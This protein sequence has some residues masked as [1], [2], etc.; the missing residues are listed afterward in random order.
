MIMPEIIASTRKR[1]SG[2]RDSYPEYGKKRASL[3]EAIRNCQ[4]KNP[5]IAE[6]KYSSP[7]NGFLGSIYT[8]E[9]IAGFYTRGG[10]TAIS[11]LTEPEYFKGSNEFLKRV[12]NYSNCPVLRKDFIIDIR[13]L[14]ESASMGADAVL[15]IVSLVGERLMQFITAADALGIELLIEVHSLAE[16][17]NALNAG[18]KLIGINNRDLNTMTTDLSTTEEIGLFLIENGIIVV[19]E[20]GINT[21][22]DI[23]RLKG[24]C[25]AFLIGSSLMRSKRPQKLLEGFVSA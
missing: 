4:E 23:R 16:A 3:I 2:L 1:V 5:V 22:S 6:I 14:E 7:S 24:K 21:E 13:Q 12:K 25:N 18:A 11:V 20:S 8:P 19:S 17:K 9:E 10:C 15:V